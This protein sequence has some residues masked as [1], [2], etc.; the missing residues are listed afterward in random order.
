[1]SDN[2]YSRDIEMSVLGCFLIWGEEL[3]DRVMEVSTEDF[4]YAE[5]KAIFEV[6]KSQD[7]IDIAI[8]STK[9]DC[10]SNGYLREAM[11]YPSTSLNFDSYLVTLKEMALNRRVKQNIKNLVTSQNKVCLDDLQSFIDD[12]KNNI[13]IKSYVDKSKGVLQGFI[14]NIGMPKQRINL[15]LS[16][17][18]KVTGGLRIPS[19][20]M[21]G[22][23]PSVGKTAFA[24]N[25]SA[26]QKQSVVFFSLEMSSEMIYERLISS[27][28]KIDYN[29]FSRQEFALEEQKKIAQAGEELRN[30]QFY[31]FDDIY[32]VE[33]QSAVIANIKPKL[34]VVDYVQKVKT[35]KKAE[36]RRNEIDYISG[37]YKQI[38]K[39]NN[40]AIILLSQLS[41]GADG[42]Q[43]PT[44]SS[45]K[46]SG[47]LE[48]DGDYVAILHRP[49]V[50]SKDNPEI[51]PEQAYILIDKNKFGNTGKLD[52]IF[53][54]KY[55]QFRE[56]DTFCG[57]ATLEYDNEDNPF[58]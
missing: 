20:T 24:L 58:V 26:H 45:L 25:I 44:M 57:T 10:N 19:V 54:G 27:T 41:R 48:A 2:F 38:A 32:D 4:Y 9:I 42:R 50:V 51:T 18:D 5:S 31:V 55:Q 17:L 56:V 16:T 30:K 46:E 22:A 35:N 37:M 47:A 34:V 49:Y 7:V 23:Y 21:L 15:G 33:G 1:M 36:N 40:C 12:E 52:L 28:K 39:H 6:M 53:N 43:N 14:K 11:T 8:I 13:F 3:K 29:L